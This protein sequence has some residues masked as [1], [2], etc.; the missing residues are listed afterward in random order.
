MK[1]FYAILGILGLALLSPPVLA[2]DNTTN[3]SGSQ[4]VQGTGDPTRGDPVNVRMVVCSAG[5]CTA[6][7]AASS[8]A[9]AANQ[10]SQIAQATL[11]NTRLGD[12]SAPAAGSV[13]A[14]LGALVTAANAARQSVGNVASGATDSGNPLKV[15]GVNNTTLPTFTNGQRGD[16]Q[17][18]TRG[19]AFTV[20]KAANSA[21]TVAVAGPAD[22]AGNSTILLYT[23]AYG[24][25]FNGTSWDRAR[26][27]VSG[28]VNQPYALTG[29]RW[30]YAAASGGI[31]NTTTA[32][33][34]TAAAGSSVRN[35]LTSLQINAGA[36]GA[37]TEVAVRDGA[38]GTV[39]WRGV[40]GTGGSTQS[41]VFPTPLRGTA[42]T[43]MEVVTLTATVTGGVYI[44]AQGY[45][46][47]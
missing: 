12:V 29:A 40:V 7:G 35:Y 4:R 41:V 38:G 2:Q 20:L 1:G 6:A 21:S 39:L 5:S 47:N 42:N 45:T 44:N 33:T 24:F 43:L 8:D 23:G 11:T 17:L 16:L 37:A 27:D 15:G 13:N 28:M 36:L 31:A 14:Q 26:G 22:G 25:G 30:Q 10:T 18:D 3:V 19:G 46:A 9:S 32:V 34:I